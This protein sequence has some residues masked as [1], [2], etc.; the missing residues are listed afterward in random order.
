MRAR[1]RVSKDA[2]LRYFCANLNN[3]RFPTMREELAANDSLEPQT[4]PWLDPG[5]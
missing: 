2:Q 5:R 3:V 4:P 1:I